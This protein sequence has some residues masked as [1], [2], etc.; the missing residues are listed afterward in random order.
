MSHPIEPAK[1]VLNHK[2]NSKSDQD[3]QIKNNISQD[4]SSIIENQEENLQKNLK[5]ILHNENQ[6]K[7]IDAEKHGND[8]ILASKRG[9]ISL[10]P[11]KLKSA[12][13]SNFIEKIQASEIQKT[14]EKPLASERSLVTDKSLISEKNLTPEKIFASQKPIVSEK[15]VFLDKPVALEKTLVSE[16]PLT[17]DKASDLKGNHFSDMDVNSDDS[18][19][20]EKTISSEK[21][22]FSFRERASESKQVSTSSE[23]GEEFKNIQKT[24]LEAGLQATEK[25]KLAEEF[26]PQN[27]EKTSDNL[28]ILGLN[29]KDIIE[30]KPDQSM[31]DF[32]NL[33]SKDSFSCFNKSKT[34]I[35]VIIL[36]IEAG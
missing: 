8:D 12:E 21:S 2:L 27:K 29:S 31:N 14:E 20:N 10:T 36:V 3:L 22:Y 32:R 4:L 23:V 15:Q 6:D 35:D 19:S 9:E 16:K 25:F 24:K 18:L 28:Q 17:Y 5:N 30:K 7:F 11:E 34:I 26:Q 33:S 13:S 1:R